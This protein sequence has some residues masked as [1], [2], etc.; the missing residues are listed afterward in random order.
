M[1]EIIP[2]SGKDSLATAII[3]MDSMNWV[4]YEFVFNPVGFELPE[5]IAWLDQVEKYLGVD[6]IRIGVNLKETSKWKS[7]FRPGINSR[8]C[9]SEGKIKPMERY[10]EGEGNIYY[11]LRADEP[12][13][14]GYINKGKSELTPIYP[15]RTYGYGLNE[16]LD[17]VNSTPC[18]PPAFY[19]E[20]MA[21]MFIAECGEDFLFTNLTDY[22]RTLHANRRV[23]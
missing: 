20:M 3:Q 9:T 19:W 8:Y 13:R 15:L 22:Q 11:G 5:S 12:E 18:K 2:I 10:F 21:D 16:V 14:I 17:L 4:E 23:R 6:I 1:R 7:G